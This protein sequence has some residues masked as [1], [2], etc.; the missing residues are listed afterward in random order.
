MGFLHDPGDLSG[1]PLAAILLEA[2]NLRASGVLAVEHGGGTSRLWFRDGRPVGAQVFTGFRPL[3]HMLLQAGLIDIDALSRSLAELARTG[4]PQGELL[5]EMGAVS[6]TDVDRLLVEQQ[7]GYFALIAA[8]ERGAYR[9]DPAVE[10]PAW[11]RTSLLSPLRTIVDALER[12]Q[13]GMLVVSALQPVAAGE[14][15]LAPGY[16]DVEGAFRWT[17]AERAL[18][19]RLLRPVRLDFFFAD[20]AVPPERA[21]AILSALLLLGLAVR[22]G[23]ETTDAVPAFDLAEPTANE[24]ATPNANANPTSVT[25]VPRPVAPG[26]S[27]VSPLTP[28]L[29]PRAT[30]PP[31][32]RSDPAD[33]RARRQRLLQQAMRNMGVGPFGNTRRPDG[34]PT[35]L[36]GPATPSPVGAR[37]AAPPGSAEDGLRKAL[38]AVAPRATERDLFARL[39]IPD[40][41]TRDDV[42]KAFLA[43]AR[44][45]HPDRFAAPSLGDLAET[46]KEFFTAVNEAYEVLTDDRRRAEYLARRKAG[47]TSSPAQTGAARV[48]FEKGEA[49]LRTRDVARA[50]GF[51]E[52]AVRADPR[53]E[54]Q[55]AL[56]FAILQDPARRDRDRARALA[57][58]ASRDAACDR[59][60]Y[61][62]GLVAR[63]E[64]DVARAERLFRAAAAANPR[65]ADALRELRALEARRGERRG[66]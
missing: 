50:R 25:R 37:P 14:V 34:A 65:N 66:R 21:R 55:A 51:Y 41:A 53:P 59:A 4:R 9:F 10:V 16:E 33:A 62:A 11:T 35:P 23:A 20:S 22:A 29:S 60:Q 5:V 63:D 48:D 39:G 52:A 32:P 24:N 17:D 56:A 61:V 40:T 42:K 57:A 49:C 19:S 2:L 43:L 64:G 1:T 36:P 27:T 18:V 31:P 30:A 44:Q 47:A 58:E 28:T 26:P 7:A 13:A 45:F 8:L 3:G 46:V 6:R 54:Y 38:L 15:R 12:P